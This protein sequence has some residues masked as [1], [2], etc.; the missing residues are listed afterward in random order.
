[1][2]PTPLKIDIDYAA[3]LI[4]GNK[5]LVLDVLTDFKNSVPDYLATL[6]RHY[7]NNNYNQLIAA[8]H[9]IGGGASYAGAKQI[10]DLAKQIELNYKQQQALDEAHYS[11]LLMMLDS[12]LKLDVSRLA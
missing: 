11:A 2:E 1:M 12:V 5:A 9:T 4:G 8:I 3:Q 6:E 10:S 7:H